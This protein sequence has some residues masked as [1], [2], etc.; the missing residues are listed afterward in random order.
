M[1]SENVFPF[2]HSIRALWQ[3]ERGFEAIPAG[4]SLRI[5]SAV[6]ADAV[7]EL[8]GG[9]ADSVVGESKLAHEPWVQM[10]SSVED[11]RSVHDSANGG[12]VLSGK[13]FPFRCNDEC[14]GVFCG[15]ERVCS[16]GNTGWEKV[17]FGGFLHSFRVVRGDDGAFADQS[18]DEFDGDG[19]SDVIGI[20]LEG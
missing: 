5:A 18:V 4:F 10:V 13:L 9:A 3:T 8:L 19:V 11:K 14:L 1:S 7:S 6:W 17:E 2:S 16:E 15:F 20:W 12:K